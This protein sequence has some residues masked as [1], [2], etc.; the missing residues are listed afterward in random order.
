MAGE[1]TVMGKIP[2]FLATGLL[3]AFPT[4]GIS[5][6]RVTLS[7]LSDQDRVYINRA[8]NWPEAA[9][10]NAIITEIEADLLP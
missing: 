1:T 5:Q 2:R 3:S 10:L 7:K 4:V 6:D 9:C 8:H